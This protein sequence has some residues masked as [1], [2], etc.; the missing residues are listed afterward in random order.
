MAADPGLIGGT[1]IFIV[2]WVVCVAAVKYF[3]RC[4]EGSEASV[5]VQV[6][7][8]VK[9]VKPERVVRQLKQR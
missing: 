3:I 4:R 9:Q 1:A 2:A 5:I 7:C 8:V 6:G